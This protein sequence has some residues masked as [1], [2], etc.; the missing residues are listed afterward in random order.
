MTSLMRKMFA[1]TAVRSLEQ[2]THPLGGTGIPTVTPVGRKRTMSA[3]ARRRI[4]A[5][6]RA[7][8]AKIHAAKEPAGKAPV[9]RKWKVS[10]AA[11]ARLSALAKA[12]WAKVK[13]AGGKGL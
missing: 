9:R 3:S 7:R 4:A 13:R 1:S 8:W 12:P 2:L 11:R 5:G 6:Q 10:A